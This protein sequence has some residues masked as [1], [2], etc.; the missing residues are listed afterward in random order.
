MQ[1][2]GKVKVGQ[3]VNIKFLNYPHIDFGMVMGV[4]KSISLIASDNNYTVEVDL[5]D[6]LKTSYGEELPFSHQMQGYAEIIT[7]D[8]RL[9]ERIFKPIKSILKRM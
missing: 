2:A 1:G 7:E 6:G 3:Q 5:P 8:I 9:L 4:I